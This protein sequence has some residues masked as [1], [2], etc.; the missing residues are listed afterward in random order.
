MY[1]NGENKIFCI[2]LP[3]TGTTSIHLA[4][5]YLGLKSIHFP[6]Q[7]W[8]DIQHPIMSEFTA[9]SD[10]PLSLL[11][12]KLD[13]AFPGSLFVLSTR[14]LNSW[15]KSCEWMF[16]YKANAW[17]FNQ[18]P[19]KTFHRALFG[20]TTF[21]KEMFTKGYHEFHN[22]ARSYFQNNANFLELNLPE[23][24]SPWKKLCGFLGAEE[25]DIPFPHHKDHRFELVDR[26][27]I[28]LEDKK[29]NNSHS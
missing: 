5:Q 14:E 15:L 13:K 7:L 25:P 24:T 22:E 20:T 11:Y 27:A 16:R 19:T 9:F 12:P 3:R 26:I 29:Y 1:K 28:W 10:T 23:E 18:E 2:G 17:A 8:E 21:D 4:F 6:K